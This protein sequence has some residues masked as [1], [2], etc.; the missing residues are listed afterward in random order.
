MRLVASSDPTEVTRFEARELLFQRAVLTRMVCRELL[1]KPEAELCRS[2][3]ADSAL[4]FLMQW[5]Y[6]QPQCPADP[7]PSSGIDTMIVPDGCLELLEEIRDGAVVCDALTWLDT[8]DKDDEWESDMSRI[9]KA[10]DNYWN[11]H[12]SPTIPSSYR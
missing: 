12:K 6:S 5:I 2:S 1:D 10:L 7:K 3:R 9:K 4:G 8:A 11:K